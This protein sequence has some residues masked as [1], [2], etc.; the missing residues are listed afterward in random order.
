MDDRDGDKPSGQQP[1]C[2]NLYIILQFVSF[3]K[4]VISCHMLILVPCSST[5]AITLIRPTNHCGDLSNAY[6]PTVTPSDL[7]TIKLYLITT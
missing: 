4:S 2:N 5:A 6:S 7:K 1:R 3:L